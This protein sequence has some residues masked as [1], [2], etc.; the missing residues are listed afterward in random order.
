MTWAIRAALESGTVD[1]LILSTDC[2]DLAR[3]GRDAGAETPFIRPPDLADD[4]APML[5]VIQHTVNFVMD[6][7]WIPEIVILFQPTAPFRLKEDLVSALEILETSPSLDSVVS[8]EAIPDHYSPHFL[9]R[10]ENDRLLPFMPNGL[11][12]TRRQ[13]APKSYTRNGQFYMTRR[14]TLVEKNSIYGD[15]CKPYVTTHKAVNLDSLHD[16]AEAEKLAHIYVEQ[17]VGL[18]RRQK[19]HKIISNTLA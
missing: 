6:S 18:L 4:A 3:I 14:A 11:A 16:W 13:D 8:V 1:R 9:M 17:T 12:V 10:I 19:R 2:E 5:P 15:N 7:G